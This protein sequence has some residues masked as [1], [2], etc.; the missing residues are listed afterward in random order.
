MTPTKIGRYEIKS[1]LGRG[2]MATVYKAHDPSFDRE[3][4]VKVLP[5]EFLHDPQFLA[6]F[7]REIKTVAQLEHPAIVPVYDVG[8]DDGQPFFVM[9]NMTGGS[10]SDWLKQGAFSLQDTARIVERLCKSLAYAHKKGIIHRDLK[11]GNVLFDNNGEAFISDFGVAKLAESASSMTGSG[12]VGTPA[13]MSPEQA[14]SGQVDSR[15]DVYA[16]GAIIYEMLTGEQPYKADT[17]M[18]LILKH[19]TEPVPEI[20][21]D[22]PDIAPEVDE[23]IK[24]AMDKNPEQRYPTMIELA[25]ALNK[26]AFGNEGVISD[27]Q[28]TRPRLDAATA[29]A[30]G[31]SGSNK[32]LIWIGAGA[33]VV[34]LAVAAIFL[35]RGRPA[36]GPAVEA[37]PSPTAQAASPIPSTF[38]PL[39]LPTETV[40][41]ALTPT[42]AAPVVVIPPGGADKFAVVSANEIWLMNPDGSEAGSITGDGSA[43]SHLQWLPDG[44]TLIYLEGTCVYSIDVTVRQPQKITCFNAQSLGGFRV[45]PD[46]KRV[47]ISID[48]QLVI[49]PFDMTA[50]GLAQNR[51]DLVKMAGACLYNRDSIKDV[52]WSKDSKRIAVVFLD[53]SN[54]PVDQIRIMDVSSCPTASPINQGVYPGGQFTIA[55]FK[56]K[57]VLPSFDWDGDHLLVFNDVV[58]NEGFGNLYYFDTKTQTGGTLAPIEGACCYRDARF[59]PDGKYLLFA[60]QD[61]RLA[62]KAVIQ[63]FYAAFDSLMSGQAGQPIPLPFGLFSDPRSSPQPALRPAQ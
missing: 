62:E 40:A 35:L 36:S 60:F 2:G 47:A 23:V 21:R 42:E 27:P 16:M 51:G 58:R 19:I 55:G 8:E 45:S 11:P 37:S 10:L 52:R 30:A 33:G 22:H 53:V 38:T 9:R 31:K 5:R 15:S 34:I 12:V 20:M 25:K 3:V 48:L 54:R 50:L 17:P 29:S 1:E 26:A 4:A 13:Y 32:N 49:V 43:K 7:R 57:Q 44:K 56:N 18:G 14:Q 63:L 46:G 28:M 39:P 61:S 41:A 6:R 59:S 24:K